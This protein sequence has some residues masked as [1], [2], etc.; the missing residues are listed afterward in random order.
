MNIRNLN[1]AL[2]CISIFFYAN[3][4]FAIHIEKSFNNWA[5]ENNAVKVNVITSTDNL[6]LIEK[7]IEDYDEKYVLIENRNIVSNDTDSLSNLPQLVNS[8]LNI[9]Q[10]NANDIINGQYYFWG[11]NNN[12]FLKIINPLLEVETYLDP[13]LQKI[14]INTIFLAIISF[15]V[16]SLLLTNISKLNSSLKN[17]VYLRLRDLSLRI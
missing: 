12:Q 9:N 7:I 4:S 10:S 11:Q 5:E 2:L 15:L 8:N 1:L 3:Y 17:V 16:I 6:Q 14:I 13:M